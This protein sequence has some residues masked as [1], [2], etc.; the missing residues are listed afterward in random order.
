MLHRLSLAYMARPLA[1]MGIGRGKIGFLLSVLQFEGIVQEELT[2]RLY[3]DRAATARALQALEEQGLVRREEDTKDR[4]RKR[5][6]STGKARALQPKIMDMLSRQNKA[7]FAGL[8][9]AEQ[10]QFLG[11]LDRLADNLRVVVEGGER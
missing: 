6:F 2:R 8:T 9:R 5:V 7:L 10:D 3:I 1:D 11:M 4:R